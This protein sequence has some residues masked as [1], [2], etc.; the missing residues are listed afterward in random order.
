MV[1][2]LQVGRLRLLPIL[3]KIGSDMLWCD[4]VRKGMIVSEL[5]K[6]ISYGDAPN[7]LKRYKEKLNSLREYGFDTMLDL[8]RECVMCG[9]QGYYHLHFH[10][11]DP[12]LKKMGIPVY[13][14]RQEDINVIIDELEKCVVLCANCHSNIHRIVKDEYL[15][16]LD[17]IHND[18]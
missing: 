17:N 15:R 12:R 9:N 14:L 3:Y 10:P 13:Q 6:R 4:E 1:C 2:I 16:W 18:I 8:K 5:D 7:R 11:I